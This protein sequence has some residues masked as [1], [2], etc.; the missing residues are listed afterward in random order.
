MSESIKV[1]ILQDNNDSTL[2][3]ETDYENQP[4]TEISNELHCSIKSTIDVPMDK[5]EKEAFQRLLQLDSALEG[6]QSIKTILDKI[7]VAV[8][9]ASQTNQ[10]T[11]ES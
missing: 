2:Y 7:V 10:D 5:R 1:A 4:N 11:T 8:W 6:D 3:G 9:E